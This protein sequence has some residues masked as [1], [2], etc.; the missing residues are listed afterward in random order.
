MQITLPV[1]SLI[2]SC[3]GERQR[4]ALTSDHK[5]RRRRAARP[6][7]LLPYVAVAATDGLL[8]VAVRPPDGRGLV[9][10]A[11]VVTLTALVA[12][13]Q[14]AAFHDNARLLDQ[15]RHQEQQLRH[16]ASHDALTQ[17]ANRAL[18][19]ERIQAALAPHRQADSLA[20]LL[21]DLD[22]F[23]SINDTLGHGVGDA[24]LVAVAERLRNCVR[25]GDTVARLGGDEFAVLLEQVEPDAVAEI[26]E[27]TLAAFTQPIVIDGHT[28]WCRR[29]SVWRPGIPTMTPASC[30]ATRTWQCTRPRSAAS[31]AM[32]STPRGWTPT[33]LS[34]PSSAPSCAGP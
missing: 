29:A 20:V 3:A 26:A 10:V 19:G 14:L 2:V 1:V 23:K 22:D 12:V 17:L 27:R 28:C 34:T 9:V 31:A 15:L 6:Y 7:S 33:S 24:L 13:R 4:R 30:C 25:P 8:L 16:Q 21:I 18:F 5:P 32:R 11:G